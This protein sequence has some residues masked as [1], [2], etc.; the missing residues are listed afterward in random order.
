MCGRL[1]LRLY[2]VHAQ[3]DWRQLLLPSS[4]SIC[5]VHEEDVNPGSKATL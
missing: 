2:R 5:M 4:L 3:T 1:G